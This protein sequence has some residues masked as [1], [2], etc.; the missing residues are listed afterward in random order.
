MICVPVR[1]RYPAFITDQVHTTAA[2]TAAIRMPTGRRQRKQNI[3]RI[4]SIPDRTAISASIQLKYSLMELIRYE[5]KNFTVS[6]NSNEQK[7][8]MLYD[9]RVKISYAL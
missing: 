1:I 7:I 2:V 4:I 3:V 5:W 8:I 6:V 9:L